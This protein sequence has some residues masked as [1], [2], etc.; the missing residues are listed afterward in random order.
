[1]ITF[2]EEV[3]ES[4][5]SSNNAIKRA[6]EEGVAEGL[7]VCAYEQTAGYGR[8]GRSWVSPFGGLYFSLLLRPSVSLQK[9]P[10]LGLV[11]ALAMRRT[12]ASFLGE[13]VRDRVQI[14][15][16]NDVI[17]VPCNPRRENWGSA[18]DKLCGISFE[19]HAGA[20]CVGIGVNVFRPAMQQEVG[21][22][23][24][25]AY[26][27]DLM[28]ESIDQAGVARQVSAEGLSTLQRACINRIRQLFLEQFGAL[29]DRW[30][31]EGFGYILDEYS[32]WLCLRG[33]EVTLVNQLDQKMTSGVVKGVDEDARLLLRTE[34]GQIEAV[35]SGEV[36]LL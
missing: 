3:H 15:W 23:N 6:I 35:N 27:A 17:L 8:L 30:C 7:V 33:C 1:M 19:R 25:P 13:S 26:V 31:N 18:F 34:Y 4:L 24:A 10:S 22:K 16:P 14:K 21:G 36:T 29:Y 2:A 32:Q 12:I 20:T 5:G 9:Q 28:G 11:V